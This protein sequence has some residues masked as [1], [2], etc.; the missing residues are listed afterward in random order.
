MH[1]EY[2]NISSE[3]ISR[4]NRLLLDLLNRETKGPFT[5][6]EAS[7]ILKIDIAKSRRIVSYWASRGWLVR[8]RRGLYATV[9][10]GAISPAERREDPW[11]IANMV[12]EPCYIGGWSAC[13]HWGLTDQIFRD[14]VVFTSSKIRRR[15]NEIQGT[16]YIV[17]H[18]EKDKILG[19]NQYGEVNTKF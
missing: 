14:I 15:K 12:F 6:L 19:Q 8:V 1:S 17:R 2:T 3:G 11:V 4:R 10:L 9:P 13:E 16:V 18:I 5:I 7:R